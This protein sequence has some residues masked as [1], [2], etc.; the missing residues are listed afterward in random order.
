M[1]WSAPQSGPSGAIR[2]V[3]DLVTEFESAGSITDG[4]TAE[5]LRVLLARA[6]ASIGEGDL[7]AAVHWLALFIDHIERQTPG[8]ITHSAAEKLVER[9]VWEDWQEGSW[10]LDMFV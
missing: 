9:I 3:N 2:A 4:E 6:E 10:P 1:T 7:R 5:G 8:H